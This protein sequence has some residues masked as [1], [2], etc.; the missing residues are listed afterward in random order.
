[1]QISCGCCA[2]DFPVT[3]RAFNATNGSMIWEHENFYTTGRSPDNTLWGWGVR[4]ISPSG[5]TQRAIHSVP[6]VSSATMPGDS[7]WPAKTNPSGYGTGVST[8]AIDLVKVV[9]NGSK[10]VLKSDW[11]VYTGTRDAASGSI[12]SDYPVGGFTIARPVLYQA[13]DAGLVMN[14]AVQSD[15]S[16]PSFP[17][18][19]S[20]ASVIIEDPVLNGTVM[21][22]TIRADAIVKHTSAGS[23]NPMWVFRRASTNASFPLYGTTSDVITALSGLPGVSSVTATGG[24]CC[25]ADMNIEVTW[26]SASN[27]FSDAWV[28]YSSKANAARVVTDWTTGAPTHIM[29]I[30]P[31]SFTSDGTGV[32]TEPGTDGVI[33]RRDLTA[34]P[35]TPFGATSAKMWTRTPFGS[36]TQTNERT[37]VGAGTTWVPVPRS[38]AVEDVRAGVILVGQTRGRVPVTEPSGAAMTTHATID[39]SAGTLLATHDSLLNIQ[40]NSWLTESG[41]LAAF[42]AQYGYAYQNGDE[43]VATPPGNSFDSSLGSSPRS[44]SGRIFATGSGTMFEPFST[45][46]EVLAASDSYSFAANPNGSNFL[47]RTTGFDWNFEA[48]GQRSGT[49][50]RSAGEYVTCRWQSFAAGTPDIV[51]PAHK[52]E[53]WLTFSSPQ[54]FAVPSDL[55]YRYVHRSGGSNVKTTAWLSVSATSSDV[56]TEL[57]AWYGEPISGYPTIS[58][59]GTIEDHDFQT[60]PF[61]QYMPLSHIA[62]WTDATGST[63]APEGRVLGLEFRNGTGA[64][65]RCV[66]AMGR[67]DGEILWQKNAGV[68]AANYPVSGL[69]EDDPVGGSILYGS[70][71][72]VVV[73][74]LCKPTVQATS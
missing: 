70:D 64:W 22:M 29:A 49:E 74:T 37:K 58:L 15:G 69:S 28:T 60:Q 7:G 38:F 53:A 1:M 6:V 52:R 20:Y 21:K 59:V 56:N 33:S 27:T 34:A 13:N 54:W 4:K 45:E 67:T 36:M 44:H 26:S 46:A 40:N 72:Q 24:P 32:I 61:W 9:Q 5:Y 55:E 43:G 14:L 63:F 17:Y 65:N 19:G 18:G 31:V 25:Q 73:Q 11:L 42:G 66:A 62:I 48:I 39:E 2:S 12:W 71:S 35:G 68:M 57:Q 3:I 8:I 50:L 41:D 30:T 16:P 23:N 10:S 51:L 47:A